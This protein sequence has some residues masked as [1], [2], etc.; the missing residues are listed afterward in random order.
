MQRYGQKGL[1]PFTIALSGKVA[2]VHM[3]VVSNIISWVSHVI[4]DTLLLY[5]VILLLS[6]L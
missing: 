6:S 5:Y 3:A 2:K 4:T 1:C